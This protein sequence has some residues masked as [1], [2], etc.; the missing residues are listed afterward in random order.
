M[1]NNSLLVG[2]HYFVDLA[3]IDLYI[4]RYTSGPLLTVNTVTD[5]SSG[6]EKDVI[7]SDKLCCDDCRSKA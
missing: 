4:A 5:T 6:T 2:I 1:G 7:M 3:F